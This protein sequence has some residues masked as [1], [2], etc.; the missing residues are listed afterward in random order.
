MQIRIAHP[1]PF[2]VLPSRISIRSP[3]DRSPCS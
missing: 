1:S 3:T 2:F